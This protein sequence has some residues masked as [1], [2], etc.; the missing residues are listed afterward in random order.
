MYFSY[1]IQD[2][3]SANTTTLQTLLLLKLG[4]HCVVNTLDLVFV[5]TLKNFT[6]SAVIRTQ[7]NMTDNNVQWDR[8]MIHGFH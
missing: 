2:S 8:S 7:I 4:S 3:F 1:K 6:I 5:F